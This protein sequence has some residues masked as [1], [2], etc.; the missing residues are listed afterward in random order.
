LASVST[1]SSSLDFGMAVVRAYGQRFCTH[2]ILDLISSC[3]ENDLASWL[4]RSM[5]LGLSPICLTLCCSHFVSFVSYA[6]WPISFVYYPYRISSTVARDIMPDGRVPYKFPM[7]VTFRFRTF[8]QCSPSEVPLRA[9][10]LDIRMPF[11]A[12]PCPPC[13]LSEKVLVSPV[14]TSPARR[15][16]CGQVHDE[17]SND[18]L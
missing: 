13:A 12:G 8:S 14:G 16:R 4:R 15:P 18:D 9:M 7:T 17:P 6:L 1:L 3:A 5:V 11:V 2:W 10:P